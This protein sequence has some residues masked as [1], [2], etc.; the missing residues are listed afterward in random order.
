M[1]VFDGRMRMAFDEDTQ[2]IGN[3]EICGTTTS[4]VVNNGNIRRHLHV[5]CTDCVATGKHIEVINS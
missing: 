2:E 3:C 5:V 1:F 4:N